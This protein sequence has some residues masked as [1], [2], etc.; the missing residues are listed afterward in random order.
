MIFAPVMKLLFVPLLITLLLTQTFSKWVLVI[1][2]NLNRDFIAKN[3]CINKT[4]PKLNCKGK[5]QVMK[6]LAQEQNQNSSN[7]T[8][9]PSKVNIPEQVYSNDIDK[10]TIPALRYATT[11]Y[12]DELL[13]LKQEARSVSIFHPPAIS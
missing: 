1:E 9:N 7:K 3:L 13:I 12:N 11:I 6:R 10:P 4:L 2:Y 8:S 5:C